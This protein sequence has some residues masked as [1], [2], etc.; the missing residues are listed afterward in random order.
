MGKRQRDLGKRGSR[1]RRSFAWRMYG[2]AVLFLFSL[3]AITTTPTFH[4]CSDFFYL[5]KFWVKI[6]KGRE[7]PLVL[8]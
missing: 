1:G 8:V 5:P 7:F 3:F 6:E 2:H 4:L